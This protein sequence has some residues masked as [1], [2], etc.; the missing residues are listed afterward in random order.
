MRMVLA[1]PGAALD[2]LFGRR[3]GVGG[4]GLVGNGVGD[5]GHQR[6]QALHVGGRAHRLDEARHAGAG[7]GQRRFAAKQP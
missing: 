7:L 5:R 2:R 6:V 4:P 1:H 3:F